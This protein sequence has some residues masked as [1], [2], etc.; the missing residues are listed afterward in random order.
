M[1]HL[2][3][4]R[5]H[6]VRENAGIEPRTVATLA[7]TV[8]GSNH[9]ARS[10]LP[11]ENFSTSL[12]VSQDNVLNAHA[13][14]TLA[15]HYL[16]FLYRYVLYSTLLH[17]PPPRFLWG[18]W[19]RTKDNCCY[20]GIDSQTQSGQ[21]CTHYFGKLDPDQ[22]SGSALT[23][24]FRSLR[25]RGSKWSLGEPWTLTIVAWRLKMEPWGSKDQWSQNR[26]TLIRRRIPIQIKASSQIQIRTTVKTKDPDPH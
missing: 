24:K 8:R 11:F 9:L 5:L 12:R 10:H 21:G 7:S 2:P 6:C 1:L 4:L 13:R 14:G 3:P 17:L 23:S 20:F 15:A 26:I 16:F 18:C 19:E 22:D 25:L